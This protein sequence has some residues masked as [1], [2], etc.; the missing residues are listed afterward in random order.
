MRSILLSGLV[1]VALAA[2]ARGDVLE[3]KDGTRLEGQVVGMDATSVT[4]EV[5]LGQ[6]TGK[7]VV[8]RADL[9]RVGL[10]EAAPVASGAAAAVESRAPVALVSTAPAP[11]PSVARP[12][13]PDPTALRQ[14]EKVVFLLDC[15]GSMAIGKRWAQAKEELL[16]RARALPA[17]GRFCLVAFHEAA[18]VQ[19][20]DFVRRNDG[21]LKRLEGALDRLRPDL[22]AGTNLAAAVAVALRREPT[23]VVLL[24]DGVATR[25][26][27]Q[28]VAAFQAVSAAAAKGLVLDAVAVQDGRW[29]QAEV[30]DFA[31]AGAVLARLARDGKGAAAAL[32]RTEEAPAAGYRPTDAPSARVDVQL[33]GVESNNMIVA[34]VLRPFPKVRVRISDPEVA[35]AVSV[36]EYGGFAWVEVVSKLGDDVLDRTGRLELAPEND[37]ERRHLRAPLYVQVVGSEDA[38]YR[39]TGDAWRGNEGRTAGTLAPNAKTARVRDYVTLQAVPGGTLEVIYHRAGET[40]REVWALREQ[41]GS[42]PRND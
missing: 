12:V 14:G 42:A 37:P 31:A 5:P 9:A 24:T 30:E 10:G 26:H 41:D 29:R 16:R 19:F 36:A 13:A 28:L 3:L 38:R 32:A 34:R 2:A 40:F 15:S 18:D 20:G 25:G 21:T 17:D 35:R 11:A 1:A 8:A 33:A 22:R 6:T 4:I 7:V 27:E 39:T 23:R